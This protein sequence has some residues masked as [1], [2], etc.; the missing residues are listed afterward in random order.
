MALPLLVF[1]FAFLWH[2]STLLV[3]TN[4]LAI[5]GAVTLGALRRTQH[6]PV[7]AEVGEYIAAGASAGFGG[8]R[9]SGSSAAA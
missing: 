6:S 1:S 2:A 3:A 4:L 8:V 9:R 5:A 7:R